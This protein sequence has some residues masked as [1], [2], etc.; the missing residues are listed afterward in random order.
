MKKAELQ[1]N[2]RIDEEKKKKKKKKDKLN[3][4]IE[5]LILEE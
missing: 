4:G 3:E 2:K 1:G 5:Y